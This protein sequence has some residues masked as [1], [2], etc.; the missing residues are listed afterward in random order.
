MYDLVCIGSAVVDVFLTIHEAN[1]HCRLNKE[2]GELCFPSGHKIPLDAAQFEIGGN[3]C[4]VAVGLSRLGFRSALVAEL[5]NDT[6]AHR[7][8]KYLEEEK[9]S[10]EHII[11]SD[12]P[13]SMAIGIQ[14]CGERT[15]FI[16]HVERKHDFNYS[17]IKTKWIYLTS[18]GEKWRHVY[19]EVPTFVKKTGYKLAFNPGSRQIDCGGEIIEAALAVSDILFLN[20]EEAEKVV[21]SIKGIPLRE[22]SRSTK[23]I[24]SN[25]EEIKILLE[26]LQRMG[27]KVV[28]ITDGKNGAFALDK[29]G[30]FY[31]Q[32]IV[33]APVVEKTGAGDSFASSFLAAIIAGHDIPTA[34]KWGAVNSASVIGKVGAQA[35]LLK[36]EEMERIFSK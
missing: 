14:F 31:K 18:I 11:I 26:Q 16:E 5:G 21:E 3:A 8:R 13:S 33:D 34:L 28:V 6:F 10:Q 15:L 29:D 12:A 20:K 24:K 35:G 4:N 23:S 30:K 17:D 7:I 1:N 2:T 25:V 22:A 19:H 32:A 27:G 9:V 36:K